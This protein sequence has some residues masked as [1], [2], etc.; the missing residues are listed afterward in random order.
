M[1]K[2]RSMQ[3]R[4]A[5]IAASIDPLADAFVAA[6]TYA[7]ALTAARDEYLARSTGQTA[8]A[9]DQ[10]VTARRG[11]RDASAPAVGSPVGGYNPGA[12]FDSPS[13]AALHAHQTYNPKSISENLEHFWAYYHDPVSGKFGYSDPVYGGAEGVNGFPL[14]PTV[15][16]DSVRGTAVGWGHN[17]GNYSRL[18]HTPTTKAGDAYSSDRF[19]KDDDIAMRAAAR[20]R[21]LSYFSLGTP[22]GNFLEQSPG[23]KPKIMVT[24]SQPSLLAP[25]APLP[26]LSRTIPIIE[27]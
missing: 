15:N 14:K 19:S 24:P 9:P 23:S 6:R 22:S 20:R 26:L 1:A 4:K 13:D 10:I 27:P 18:D 8:Q 21:G 11:R 25:S 16:G 3:D 5:Q 12:V 17:H 7:D 2:A